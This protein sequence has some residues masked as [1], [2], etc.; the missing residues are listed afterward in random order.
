MRTTIDG[1]GPAV[2]TAYQSDAG[3]WK[4]Y[5]STTSPD[6]LLPSVLAPSR[7]H[8]Q[9]NLVWLVQ[10]TMNISKLKWNAFRESR[11]SALC[12]LAEYIMVTPCMCFHRKMPTWPPHRKE[13]PEDVHT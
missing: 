2:V 12:S 8:Y 9:A 7:G 3:R 10:E 1:P 6:S 4:N 11:R 5:S 13:L